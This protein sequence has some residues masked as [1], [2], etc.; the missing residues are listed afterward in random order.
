MNRSEYIKPIKPNA[1]CQG[2]YSQHDDMSNSLG[3]TCKDGCEPFICFDSSSIKYLSY[4]KSAGEYGYTIAIAAI[5][6]ALGPLGIVVALFELLKPFMGKLA[7]LVD[8]KN[9]DE[10]RMRVL[11]TAFKELADILQGLIECRIQFCKSI[12]KLQSIPNLAP[13][14]DFGEQGPVIAMQLAKAYIVAVNN[15]NNLRWGKTKQ[16]I[17]GVHRYDATI[18][19]DEYNLNPGH[20]GIIVPNV[21]HYFMGD[22]IILPN[23]IIATVITRWGESKVYTYN[24]DRLRIDGLVYPNEYENTGMGGG[25]YSGLNVRKMAGRGGLMLNLT[26]EDSFKSMIGQSI[27]LE[28]PIYIVETPGEM[29]P[30]VNNNDPVPGEKPAENLT[31]IEK[32]KAGIS[33]NLA[34]ILLIG[35]GVAMLGGAVSNSNDDDE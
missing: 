28:N 33:G 23:G 24:K 21:E 8:K 12:K 32:I 19:G 29:P 34:S 7:Y 35:I 17:I 3:S 6:I 31:M 2:I 25:N 15:A 30:A 20:F 10:E 1:K 27:E 9:A 13:D 16:K 26:Y 4:P 5:S 14:G 22:K 11:N 18:E